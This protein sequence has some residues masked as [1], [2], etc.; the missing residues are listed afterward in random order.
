MG[1]SSK[2]QLREGR[3]K[4]SAMANESLNEWSR[5]RG[6]GEHRCSV[7]MQAV[8]YFL[9]CARSHSY[10]VSNCSCLHRC[11]LYSVFSLLQPVTVP[12]A[13]SAPV[14]VKHNSTPCLSLS[15][16][17]SEQLSFQPAP[18]LPSLSC[19]FAPA[20]TDL[21][22]PPL[23]SFLLFLICL[24]TKT[25]TMSYEMRLRSPF[26]FCVSPSVETQST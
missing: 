1:E 15:T 2:V 3:V 14:V 16:V 11:F 24:P 17:A 25:D 19:T 10:F 4:L 12:L 18:Q 20:P 8:T 13:C 22:P 5:R 21:S 6:D 23:V 7:S 26:F 9:L